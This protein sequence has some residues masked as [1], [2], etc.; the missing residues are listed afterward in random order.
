MLS[1]LFNITKENKMT[2]LKRFNNILKGILIPSLT[3]N[4]I[5]SLLLSVII[6][7]IVLLV[8]IIL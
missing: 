3:G 5:S 8:G 7:L 6:I 1:F 4:L 2:G